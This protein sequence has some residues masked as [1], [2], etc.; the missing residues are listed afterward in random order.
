MK[1]ADMLRKSRKPVLLVVNKVD[2]FNKFLIDK[3]LFYKVEIDRWRN[4][5]GDLF[6]K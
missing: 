2:D 3:Q 1:V 4:A 6:D 5:H